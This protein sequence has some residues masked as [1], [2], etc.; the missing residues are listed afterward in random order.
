MGTLKYILNSVA[1]TLGVVVSW[2]LQASFYGA[3]AYRRGQLLRS[4][5]ET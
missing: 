5:I 2:C 4:I 3:I 1:I